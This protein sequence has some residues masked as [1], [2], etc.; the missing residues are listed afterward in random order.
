VAA[1]PSS[2]RIVDAELIEEDEA[3]AVPPARRATR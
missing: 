3:L 1:V 2:P